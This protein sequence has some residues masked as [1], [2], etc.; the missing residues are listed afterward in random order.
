[1]RN[2]ITFVD[3]FCGAGGFTEGILLAGGAERRFKLLAASDIHEN[4]HHTHT[5]RFSGQLGLDYEFITSDIRDADF[6]DRLTQSVGDESVDLVVGGPP[7]QGFSLFGA[8]EKDDPRN[9]LFRHYLKVIAALRP[10]Y[11]VMENVP[12]L[13]MMYG[14]ETVREMYRAV[15]EMKGVKYHLEGPI[16]V[17]ASEFGVPQMRERLLF[18]GSRED[19]PVL[20]QVPAV[21]DRSWTAR[22]AL[23]DLS[24]L[25]S[26]D[27]VSGYH[28]SHPATNRYQTESRRGRLFEMYGIERPS[29]CLVGHEASRHTP[30]V[31]ARFAM[32]EPG[33]GFD[34]IPRGL[35][36]GHLQSSKK[37]C[38][39][40]DPDRPAYTVT[41]LPDDF[42]HYRQHRIL[43]A[44]EWA[45]LQSFD[46]TFEF[47]GPRAT[48]GG[49]KGN[50]KRT[51]ALPQYTQIGNAVPPL[52]A[53]G[54][55]AAILS[56][57]ESSVPIRK[58]AANDILRKIH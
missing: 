7:C 10:K 2:E 20:D 36:E 25:R 28:E 49:G 42:V 16:K 50:K 32:M 33:R 58:R 47:S 22:E 13:A 3:L 24:F 15:S 19:M 4:A 14:G 56:A 37:W 46:D 30:D 11:F 54:I 9:D 27:E 51:G 53:R 17:N 26:W 43:T 44:R 21:M 35:W 18:I 41:T 6:L 57:I 31:I 38:V 29:A 48:G 1:M 39:R 23:D 52:L 12:G 34:S 5:G 45:R 40:L 55:G 8:R